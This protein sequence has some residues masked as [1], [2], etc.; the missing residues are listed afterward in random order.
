MLTCWACGAHHTHGYMGPSLI[1]IAGV[2]LHRADVAPP[3]GVARGRE[4]CLPSGD[5]TVKVVGIRWCIE[6][7]PHPA[8]R[9]AERP[10][11]PRTLPL[12]TRDDFSPWPDMHG[13]S[14]FTQS[15]GSPAE[16]CTSALCKVT[17]TYVAD[18]PAA[19]RVAPA[20]GSS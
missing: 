17:P 10:R 16:R 6:Q 8:S 1:R 14:D 19:V 13:R 11:F 4:A 2:T 12:E 18:K 9:C 5:T 20:F 15:R 7:P 3:N